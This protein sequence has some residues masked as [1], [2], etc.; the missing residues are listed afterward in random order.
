MFSSMGS[1]GDSKWARNSEWPVLGTE[2][3]GVSVEGRSVVR[4]VLP[5]KTHV[6][7]D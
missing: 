3:R 7:G 1:G 5:A 4:V 2:R 6:R